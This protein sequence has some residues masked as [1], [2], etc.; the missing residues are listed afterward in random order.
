MEN[1]TPFDDSPTPPVGAEKGERKDVTYYIHKGIEFTK[2]ESIKNTPESYKSGA[3]FGYSC[4]YQDGLAAASQP[5]AEERAVKEV[6][7][8]CWDAINSDDTFYD[9]APMSKE[10]FIQEAESMVNAAIIMK[11][12][13][14]LQ[15]EASP[16]FDK[17]LKNMSEESKAKVD[18]AL[19]EIAEEGKSMEDIVSA[20]LTGEELEFFGDKLGDLYDCM[21]EWASIQTA[22]LTR[23]NKE[24]RRALESI[25]QDTN[26][27]RMKFTAIKALSQTTYTDKTE[28]K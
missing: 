4:G 3:G 16:E 1:L 18:K 5:P 23:Q 20:E 6:V 22:S 27:E 28:K 26:V 11:R 17:S 7:L 8:N 2:S 25:Y 10:R 13:K 21:R 24:L 19:Q 9:S 12:Y 14:K 15:S